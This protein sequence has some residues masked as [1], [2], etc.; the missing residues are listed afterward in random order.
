MDNLE[1]VL[2]K[3]VSVDLSYKCDNFIHNIPVQR[4][5]QFDLQVEI[6]TLSWDDERNA[7]ENRRGK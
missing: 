5:L 2:K 6:P 1:R 7:D 3:L 4:R